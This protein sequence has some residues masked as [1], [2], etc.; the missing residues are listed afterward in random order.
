LTFSVS[1]IKC[2]ERMYTIEVFKQKHIEDAVKLFTSSY[3]EE[4]KKST[5]LPSRVI[6]EPDWIIQELTSILVNPGVASIKEGKLVGFMCTSAFF[7]FKEQNA[8]IIPEFAHSSIEEDKK[9]IYQLMYM[10]LAPKWIAQHVCLHLIVHFAHDLALRNTLFELGFGSVVVEQLRGLSSLSD[11][12]PYDI[13]LEKDVG[14][15]ID[16]DIEHRNYYRESPIFLV[17]A[18]DH[19]AAVLGLEK[20]VKSDDVFLVYYENKEPGVYFVVGASADSVEG[21]LLRDTNTAQVKSAYAKAHLRN[22]GIGKA[23]LQRSIEWAR[24]NKYERLFVEHETANY[25]GGRFW[26]HF[27]TPYVYASMRYIDSSF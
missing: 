12:K 15:L 27:F 1:T 19:D 13:V 3:L 25:Y 7:K 16:L 11:V 2:H 26:N 4:R 23:L 18:V 8:A 10:T 6:T 22:M 17:K 5:L 14:K 24:D 9:H 21:F 20:H